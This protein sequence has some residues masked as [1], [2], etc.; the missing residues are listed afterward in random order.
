VA[1]VVVV[2]YQLHIVRHRRILRRLNA[3]VVYQHSIDNTP[4]PPHEATGISKQRSV[5]SKWFHPQVSL[6]TIE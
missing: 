4:T 5:W 1:Q 6:A 3:N 2:E